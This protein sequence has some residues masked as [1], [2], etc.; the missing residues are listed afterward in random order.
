MLGQGAASAFLALASVYAVTGIVTF[1]G[2]SGSQVGG[3]A[4]AGQLRS[5]LFAFAFMVLLFPT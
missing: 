1:P 3:R 5:C 4:D 2:R